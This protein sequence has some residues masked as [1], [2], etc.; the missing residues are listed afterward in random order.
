MHH[1]R[2]N[3]QQNPKHNLPKLCIKG[4]LHH[5]LQIQTQ[6]QQ[7]KRPKASNQQYHIKTNSQG[8]PTEIESNTNHKTNSKNNLYFFSK[9]SQLQICINF[10]IKIINYII[11][12][13]LLLL[14][15]WTLIKLFRGEVLLWVWNLYRYETLEKVLVY[16]PAIDLKIKS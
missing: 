8:P 6:E 11:K 4:G 3:Q 10:C 12:L 15:R 16:V 9:L 13:I 5:Q 14:L 7:S 2:K 1:S